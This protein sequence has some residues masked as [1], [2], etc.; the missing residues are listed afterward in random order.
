MIARAPC[1]D[2]VHCRIFSC[3]RNATDAESSRRKVKLT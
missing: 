3:D 1:D 2:D